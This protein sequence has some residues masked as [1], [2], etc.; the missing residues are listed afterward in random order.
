ME[1]YCNATNTDNPDNQKKR[2][3]IADTAPR[4]AS[5]FGNDSKFPD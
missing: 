4:L 5:Y 3:V 1:K 2:R